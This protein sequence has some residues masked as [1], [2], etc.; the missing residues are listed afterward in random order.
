[1]WRSTSVLVVGSDHLQND[2]GVR[3][4]SLARMQESR[5]VH[6]LLL[7]KK[8]ENQY[9]SSVCVLVNTRSVDVAN[10]LS[11]SC[12]IDH[13]KQLDIC[14]RRLQQRTDTS[15]LNQI[16]QCIRGSW[17]GCTEISH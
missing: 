8:Q 4:D 15:S 12:Q 13:L 14:K 3:S 16:Q 11:L 9:F 1:M 2:F 5:R 7:W 10:S 6:F 17:P